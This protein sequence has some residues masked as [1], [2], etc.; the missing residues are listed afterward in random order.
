M[1]ES[2]P[3][4]HPQRFFAESSPSLWAG[5]AVVCVG[6]VAAVSTGVSGIRPETATNFGSAGFAAVVFAGGVLGGLT[7]FVEYV[8]LVSLGAAL[9]S[10][11]GSAAR[12][13]RNVAWS[14]TPLTVANVAFAA[15]VWLWLLT[16]TDWT[17]GGVAPQRPAWLAFLNTATTALANLGIGY[18]LWYG[19][20]D[21]HDVSQQQAGVVAAVAVV[22]VLGLNLAV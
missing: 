10:D 13:A 4:L 20:Q 15:A 14:L 3:R 9:T 1:T 7:N 6:G 2:K 18:V 5:L 12:S 11:T 19:V 22:A 17:L 21:A 16:G 8:L